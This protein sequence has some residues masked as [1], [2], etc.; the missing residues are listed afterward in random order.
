MICLWNLLSSYT[1]S[2]FVTGNSACLCRGDCGDLGD[3]GGERIDSMYVADGFIG[4]SGNC[5]GL[6]WKLIVLKIVEI[7]PRR[8]CSSCVS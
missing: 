7:E 3:D 5:S 2:S 6:S 1:S 4:G 8:I